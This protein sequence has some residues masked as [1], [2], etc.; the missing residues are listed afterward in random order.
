MKTAARIVAFALL[1]SLTGCEPS[2]TPVV[3]APA[4]HPQALAHPN[5]QLILFDAAM[6]RSRSRMLEGDLRPIWVVSGR[7]EN[8]TQYF[9]DE[10][11]VE[12]T[13]YNTQTGEQADSS[14]IKMD[15]LRLPPNNSVVAFSRSIQILP[16]SVGWGWHYEIIQALTEP[17]SGD[18]QQ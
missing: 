6:V 10:V 14:V 18:I 11:W 17:E 16:P 8:H 15:H 9:I 12:V 3:P 13:L 4:P 1:L 5:T 2:S 7:L